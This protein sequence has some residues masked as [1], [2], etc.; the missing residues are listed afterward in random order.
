MKKLSST[1]LM[2]REDKDSYNSF[3]SATL[4]R[5]YPDNSYQSLN[6]THVNLFDGEP[7][8]EP[9]GYSAGII[10]PVEDYAEDDFEGD[11]DIDMVKSKQ[12]SINMFKK[13]VASNSWSS[14]ATF[15]L[16]LNSDKIL[17][18]SSDN[19]NGL[20]KDLRFSTIDSKYDLFYFDFSKVK[21]SDLEYCIKNALASSRPHSLGFIYGIDNSS[22]KYISDL[23][24]TKSNSI[25]LDNVFFLK[26]NDLKKISMVRVFDES[27]GE[28]AKFLC[29]VAATMED[30]IAGLQPYKTL[31][32][33]SGLLFPYD[34]P[35]DVTYHMGSVSF[36]IDIIFVGADQRIKKIAKNIEP[37][38]LGVFGSA[39]TSLV[40]E[41]AGGASTALGISVGDKIISS[42]VS[43]DEYSSFDK[44]YHSFS[45]EKNI[46]VKN[47]S[48][49]KK[50]AF[51]NFE[52]FNISNTSNQ[53]SSLIKS[54]SQNLKK[55]E[56][57][58]VYNF[59]NFIS[60]GAS[61][62]NNVDVSLFLKCASN[63]NLDSGKSSILSN[64]LSINSFTPFEIRRAFKS[65]QDDLNLGKKVV[66][67]TE[68]NGNLNMFKSLIIKRASEE[69]IFD[70]KI[71]S[72]DV[73]SIPRSTI[74]ETV[75]GLSDRYSGLSSY[76]NITLSKSAGI[77]IPDN[78]KSDA[79]EALKILLDVKKELSNIVDLFKHNS[80][81]YLKHKDKVD[82][83]KKTEKEYI[84]SSKRISK[85]IV[86][87][88]LGIKKTIKI[89]TGIK[90]ISSVDEKIESL[91][92]ACKEFVETAE[93]IFE[94]SAKTKE[95]GFPDL[96][97][98]ETARIEKSAEDIE[99]NINNFCDYI[100]KNILN[101]KILSR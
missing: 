5:N 37:G 45:N 63:I 27:N 23:G 11:E 16:K 72:I 41:I 44:L 38:T 39:N 85:K 7:T 64:F 46:Y 19:S 52:I 97:A 56:D 71:H 13:L 78:V 43:E 94:L 54:A 14:I 31:K 84:L 1:T 15:N 65:I 95:D 75:I 25:S 6:T 4:E 90:D 80:E 89:M 30:K 73:I 47:A 34:R 21:K 3:D 99:N 20:Y 74:E 28:R 61:S 26:K 18:Y 48:F 33:G 92:L 36:P 58:V 8:A 9:F 40:L 49:V 79:S 68:I 42:N 82:L 62:I 77:A 51:N 66:I 2:S 35:Q 101:K 70:K 57:V 29:D 59:D 32:Y 91:S 83:I 12:A 86:T 53:I 69:F 55:S 76:N 50:I 81:E 60:N 87:M 24:F 93:G 100:S 96:L 67:A 22:M 98:T 17:K 10:S 88:L